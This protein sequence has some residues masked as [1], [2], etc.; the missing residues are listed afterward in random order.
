[1]REGH[2]LEHDF[3]DFEGELEISDTI[4]EDSLIKVSHQIEAE[5]YKSRKQ[6]RKERKKYA[7]KTFVFLSIFTG[8]ILVIVILSAIRSIGFTLSDTVL[9][10]L[11]TTSFS[12]V[13]G[14]FILV[15]RYLFR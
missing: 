15:M 1:M 6:D 14:I 7:K 2:S 12:T 10:T 5:N 4:V 13:V 3:E 11:I 9:I 8:I